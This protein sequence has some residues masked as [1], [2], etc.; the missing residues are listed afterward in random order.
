MKPV[1]F[2]LICFAL[3]FFQMGCSRE[4]APE[5]MVRIA[6]FPNATHAQA[7]IMRHERLLEKHL[8]AG[9]EVRYL[10]F[11]AGASEIEGFFS[12]HV[13]IGY[14]GPIPAINGHVKSDG[15]IKIVSGS[16]FSGAS[17][18]VGIDSDI[19]SFS[20][21]GNQRIALPQYGNTQHIALLHQLSK[22]NLKDKSQG[23]TVDL[24]F[25]KNADVAFLFEKNEIDAAYI[26]EPWASDLVAR[27][28]ARPIEESTWLESEATTLIVSNQ[29]TIEKKTD[30]LKAF[31]RA[32][33]E[34][35]ELIKND[36]QKAKEI[37]AAELEAITG[38]KISK[39]S[40]DEAFENVIFDVVPPLDS[41]E[42]YMMWFYESGFI[43]E[44]VDVNQLF[45]LEVINRLLK[46]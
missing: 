42:L 45:D 34:A 4:R 25:S 40:I 39:T 23:G 26:P 31:L 3:L 37:V 13:D 35:T 33:L 18:V 1:K 10:V 27:G 19:Q 16:A 2:A 14:I 38:K 20:E 6:H 21:L 32:H 8:P 24:Y 5:A 44:K 9:V 36:P 12:N 41:V 43:D 7:L 29:E 28:L 22:Y 17:L 46:D 30:W 15:D 11:N